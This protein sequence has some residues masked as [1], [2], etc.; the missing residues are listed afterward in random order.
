MSDLDISSAAARQAR[1][2]DQAR[3]IEELECKCT[4]QKCEIEALRKDCFDEAMRADQAE[5]ALNEAIARAEQAERE[6]DNFEKLYQSA[7]SRFLSEQARRECAES[8]REGQL[9]NTIAFM[10]ERD[11]AI[12]EVTRLSEAFDGIIAI[13]NGSAV[14][15]A[16]AALQG[17]CAALKKDQTDD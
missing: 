4:Q 7:R 17:D 10:R 9:R 3:K 8:S 14:T 15:I 2:E 12:A 6:R 11:A 13:G 1:V 16:L 5:I